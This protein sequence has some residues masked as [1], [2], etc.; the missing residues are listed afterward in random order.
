MTDY[1]LTSMSNISAIFRT[2][3]SIIYINHNEMWGYVN[4]VNDF[5]LSLKFSLCI[6]YNV[7][8]I[9]RNLQK[10]SLACMDRG[11]LHVTHN[12]PQSETHIS[13][14]Q[15]FR[16]YLIKPYILKNQRLHNSLMLFELNS[17]INLYIEGFFCFCFCFSIYMA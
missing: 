2:T 1:Y 4:P 16:N 13:I 7:P 9:F 5:W 11:T 14:L 12:G 17:C 10:R 8:T 6:G 3:S 15:S